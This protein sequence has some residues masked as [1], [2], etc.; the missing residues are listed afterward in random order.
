MRNIVKQILYILFAVVG[1]GALG[2]A[3]INL[4][5]Q[6]IALVLAIG[7][8]GFLVLT[9]TTQLF[10]PDLFIIRYE[11]AFFLLVAFIIAIIQAGANGY[12]NLI[13]IFM[14]LT[15]LNTGYLIFSWN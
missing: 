7:Y 9:K 4:D 12:T 1:I 8:L 2:L 10:A 5:E 6:S 3:L 15:L 11:K 13:F 14:F